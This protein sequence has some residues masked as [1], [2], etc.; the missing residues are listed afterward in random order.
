[1]FAFV[2]LSL[3]SF[4]LSTPSDH[5]IATE[6]SQW[7]DDYSNLKTVQELLKR[8][9]YSEALSLLKDFDRDN[10]VPDLIL[11]YRASA[12]RGVGRFEES[13]SLIKRLRVDYPDSPFIK[14]GMAIEARNY[15]SILGK[16]TD[17]STEIESLLS[18]YASSHPDDHEVSFIFARYLKKKGETKRAKA[19]FIRVYKG[20]S[21]YSE[22]A[23]SELDIPD[24]TARILVEKATNHIKDMEYRKAEE[25]LRNAISLQD[26][27][28]YQEDI[29][30]KLGY[31]LFMQKR[32]D[33][34]AEEYIK[35]GDLYNAARSFFRKGDM[36]SFN[37]ILSRLTNMKDKRAGSLI[38]ALAWKKRRDGSIDEALKL[39]EYVK[40]DYPLLE[41]DAL[42]GIAWAYYRESRY[43]DARNILT[44]L[45]ER[46][47]SRRYAYWLKRCDTMVDNSHPEDLEKAVPPGI[48]TED[49]EDSKKVPA[50]RT[51][52]KSKD[53]LE[54]SSD[55]FYSLLGMEKG[56]GIRDWES[57]RVGSGLEIQEAGP[58]SELRNL[59]PEL[60]RF[61][62]L[63]HLGF[64][65]EAMTELMREI[66]KKPAMAI[67]AAY[68]L[69][70]MG[71]YRNAIR[72]ASVIKKEPDAMR[73]LGFEDY[74]NI[75]YP[76]AFWPIIESTSKKF[77]IDPLLLLSIMREESRYEPGARSSAGA[78]GLMQ[79]MPATARRL[80]KN[81]GLETK[82]SRD[83]KDI[84]I[85]IT[86]GAFYL[87][88]L[89]QELRSIPIA[90]AAY[91]VGEEKVREWINKWR[92]KAIDEFVED[93]PYEETRNYVKR[94][95]TTYAT[96]H[97]WYTKRKV[98]ASLF[99]SLEAIS[100][101]SEKR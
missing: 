31:S 82:D 68:Y 97:M 37:K 77:E 28:V 101:I 81:T 35:A 67:G 55:D 34:A 75:M 10:I 83:I 6:E 5:A 58:K 32:Y 27:T 18:D 65:D 7:K 39:F 36:D 40:R 98:P 99:D 42:W 46:F 86:L 8:E 85:N 76:L 26:R 48:D 1:M 93:I 19:L 70:Q 96:Y 52:S 84:K 95:L 41:E 89:I 20:N 56:M 4:L 69:Q 47:P 61:R 43:N 24:I 59:D 64:Q 90:I 66:K 11:L 3:L 78:L 91:N 92:Y 50:S 49:Q 71:F 13:N 53:L 12:E 63:L 23:L 80:I 74:R 62:I 9:R 87:K 15:I 72:L 29:L 38:L 100:N 51:F 44:R 94:V 45:N 57:R 60:S 16:G 54:L 79:L 21:I 73:E 17:A 22:D 88:E 2:I 30:K 25:I 33:R 14:K